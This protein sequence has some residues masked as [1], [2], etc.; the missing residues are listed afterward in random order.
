MIS[1]FFKI[2][3]QMIHNYQIYIKGLVQGVGFR[4]FIHRMA[5][6]MKLTGSVYNTSDGIYIFI[7]SSEANKNTFI[8]KI[9]TNKPA[10]AEIEEIS[11][12]K[13]NKIIPE[14]NRFSIVTSDFG[15][16]SIT[17]ISPDIAI[18]NDCLNDVK[19][20]AHRLHYPF[21]NCTHCGPRFSIIK[22]LPYDRDTT[23]M[24]SFKMCPICQTEYN[25]AKD[26]R[27]HAQPI[28]CNTCGPVYQ[29][30][31]LQGIYT[32]DY[33][34]ILS[35]VKECIIKGGIVTL[36][37]IGGYNLICNATDPN[38]IKR[39]RKIK[40]RPRKP[41]AVMFYDKN[42]A[43]KYVFINNDELQLLTSW[44]RPI[45]LLHEK[46]K[47]C[48][49]GLNDGYRTLGVMLPYTLIHHDL[50]QSKEITAIVITSANSDGEPII[51]QDSEARC[52]F[53]QITDLVIEYNRDIY[54]RED[55]SVTHIISGKS[56]IIRRSRGYVPE[57]IQSDLHVEGIFALG[58]DLNN[59]FAIGKN[60][61]II[62]SQYIGNMQEKE[63]QIFFET[64]M[65]HFFQ[66]FRF[67]PKQIICDLHPE[68]FS[69]T[70]AA[71]Y[72]IQHNI[73]LLH[74]QHHHA[75]AAAVMAEYNL[76][77]DVLAVC[78]DGTG[79]GDDGCSWGGEI[80][81]CNYASY[82]RLTHFEYVP[83][84]GGNAASK[85]PW[86]M[87]ISYLYDKNGIQT[88]YPEDFIERIGKKKINIIEAM[89]D[90]NV[91]SP[92]SSSAGRLFD[93]ISSL[94]G[95][96]D[97][98]TYQS[99][100]AIK[101]EQVADI[102]CEEFYPINKNNPLDFKSLVKQ[103]AKDYQ[104]GVPASILSSRF[105]NT[106]VYSLAHTIY[107]FS[108]TTNNNKVILSG[109]VFQNKLLS[110]LLIKQLAAKKLRVFFP[111]KIPCNDG[112][113]AIGQMAIAAAL[114]NK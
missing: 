64:S 65:L 44:R 42:Q 83:L 39:L 48:S 94:I 6:E 93:T 7:Q 67:S 46:Q 19:K 71:K 99:E 5:S 75:H 30:K 105:H 86:R 51:T 37:S 54:N 17:R 61:D 41:F 10:I 49:N 33:N 80:L 43:E 88:L 58:A 106:L 26:R 9:I 18:C 103:I 111:S 53:G 60:K 84:P 11:V 50:L 2:V 78:L 74:V 55:D 95:I 36:K 13:T 3:L 69:T 40:M 70:I 107:Y 89:I 91:L 47:I 81:K 90:R 68:Y 100:A 31:N 34:T 79:Y 35:S 113:I 97:I 38:A 14:N 66:I 102:E 23:T 77:E 21:I 22:G 108:K 98:N 45:V 72:S 104:L 112:S 76:N 73:P 12:K 20:Q 96:C 52:K 8:N 32:E 29:M 82:N 4:P 110:N 16:N 24:N 15:N 59:A 92:L 114:T 28:A 85:E 87:V 109:G 63:N 25:N 27:F 56:R 101:L 57:P 1:P 62:L